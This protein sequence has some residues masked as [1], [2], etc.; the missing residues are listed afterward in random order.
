MLAAK[1]ANEKAFTKNQQDRLNEVT[2]EIV[3]VE[4]QIELAGDEPAES[5]VPKG[6]EKM[7]HILIATGNRFDPKT[8]KEINKPQRQAFT[9][10]EWQLF[11]KN[12]Q[13][14]GYI[15]TKVIHDPYGEVSQFVK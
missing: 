9:Y 12:F 6:T 14:L 2:E 8:G 5:P 13:R 7:V 10:G 3:D 4:E 11:K 1:I 15:I